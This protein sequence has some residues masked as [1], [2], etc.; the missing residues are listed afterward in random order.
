[1][2][3]L[4]IATTN[5]GKIKEIEKLLK[6]DLT[7]V[8]LYSLA[9]LNIE[10]DCPENGATFYEN[11][12]DK[13]IFYSKLAPGIYT[14]AD[15]SGLVVEAL[16]GEPGVYSARYAGA[17]CDDEKNIE[18]LLKEMSGEKNK[19]AK[20]VTVIVIALDGEVIDSFAGEAAGIILPERRGSKGFGYDPVFYY[21][22]LERTFAQLS[23][24]E[25]NEVSH[26]AMALRK[27]KSFLADGIR[28]L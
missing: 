20:F 13:A 15:D 22:P 4:L 21:P 27:L 11:A 19:T 18:K 6:E 10:I 2:R 5:R 9:D 17:E 16:Q 28:S 8:T 14:A 1:M 7:G 23:T 12:A 3:K 26:R 25:K 24:G